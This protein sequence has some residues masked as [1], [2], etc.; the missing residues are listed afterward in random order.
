MKSILIFTALLLAPLASL[1]AAEPPGMADSFPLGV[2]WPWERTA[3]LAQRNGLEK[4]DFV[5]R[6][7]DHLKSHGFDAVW[8]VTCAPETY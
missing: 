8:A 4:R 3:G 6:C 5:E 1:Q 7:L 2:Y